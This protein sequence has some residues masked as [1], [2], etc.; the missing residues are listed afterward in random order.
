MKRIEIQLDAQMSGL[1]SSIA[2]DTA[3][4]PSEAAAALLRAALLEERE[5]AYL[6]RITNDRIAAS[7]E[8][9]PITH[10]DAWSH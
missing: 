9:T 1:L 5:D 6:A 8:E 2:D 4:S 10:Q 3:V 7:S